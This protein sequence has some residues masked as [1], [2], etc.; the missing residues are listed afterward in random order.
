MSQLK[1]N[2]KAGQNSS[3]VTT[4]DVNLVFT[5]A[6]ITDAINVGDWA[7]LRK[8]AK[9]GMRANEFIT[10]WEDSQRTG[11]AVRVGKQVGVDKNAQLEG[12]RCEMFSY[13]LLGQDG[14]VIPH[15][16]LIF[17]RREVGRAELLDIWNS[18]W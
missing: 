3:G 8:L 2:P 13:E 4:V 12:R 9:P 15:E 7:K 14:V 1:N 6:T 17:V 10:M 18:G 11:H 16:L 5:I